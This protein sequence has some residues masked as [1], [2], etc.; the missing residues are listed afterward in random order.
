MQLR[1]V[2]GEIATRR[3]TGKDGTKYLF[4]DQQALFGADGETSWLP[5]RLADDQAAYPPGEYELLASSF[6]VNREGRLTLGRINLRP[7]SAAPA[8]ARAVPPAAGSK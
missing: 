3:V 4:R 6:Y 5:I 7:L 8:A 1:I 2:S